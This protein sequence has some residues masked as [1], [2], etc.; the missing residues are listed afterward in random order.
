M[1]NISPMTFDNSKTIITFRVRQVILTILLLAY[2]IMAFVAAI[3]KFPVLGMSET[4]LTLILVGIWI[5]FTFV[6]ALLSY[7]FVYFSDD[8]EK[9]VIRY[10]NAGMLGWKEECGGD[11]QKFLCRLQDRIKLFRTGHKHYPSAEFPRR[12]GKV[13]SCIHQC[14][15]KR[16]EGKPV[17]C[18]ELVLPGTVTPDN[19]SFIIFN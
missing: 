17:S 19:M 16:A 3:I 12:S 14:S 2:I 10:F 15:Y 5:L 7:Q 8:T 11:R 18:P 4:V 6:P 1:I 13:S 9:I